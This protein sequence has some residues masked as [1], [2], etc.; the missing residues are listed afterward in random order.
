M[1]LMRGQRWVLDHLVAVRLLGE[2]AGDKSDGSVVRD[3]DAQLLRSVQ[4]RFLIVIV[5]LRASRVFDLSSGADRPS[6]L[7]DS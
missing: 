6:D 5:R 4:A 7:R 2:P 3:G 1:G